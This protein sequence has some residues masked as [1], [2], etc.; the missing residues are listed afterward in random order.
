MI[1]KTYIVCDGGTYSFTLPNSRLFNLVSNPYGWFVPAENPLLDNLIGWRFTAPIVE[2]TYTVTFTELAN[3][4]VV[5]WEV[6]IVVTSD[7]TTTTFENCCT[8]QYNIVWLNREGGYQNYIFTG[9]REFTVDVGDAKTYITSDYIT[10]YSEVTGVFD[11]VI[12]TTGDI[13]RSH[14]DSLASLQYAIQAWLY[15]EDE[16]E[17]TE[18]LLDKKSFV[19]RKST[20]KFFDV[21]IRFIL[22]KELLVQ[23]G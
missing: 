9:V 18:I 14:V 17:Y 20:D 1:Y 7:C 15:D 12:A 5:N 3:G 19:K 6:Q 2:G 21:R 23:G 11:G 10:K 4:E 8:N 16:Q 13:P 22:A